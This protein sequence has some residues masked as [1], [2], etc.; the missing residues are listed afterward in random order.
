[1]DSRFPVWNFQS[2]TARPRV[3][4]I[5][6]FARNDDTKSRFAEL[7]YWSL[8]RRVPLRGISILRLRR[9]PSPT[10]YSYHMSY[11]TFISHPARYVPYERG[12]DLSTSLPMMIWSSALH[13]CHTDR[14]VEECLFEAHLSCAFGAPLLQG[15]T[16]MACNTVLSFLCLR[17]YSHTSEAKIPRIRFR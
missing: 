3:T 13:S 10:G 1:M 7:A 14:C 5:S 6:R 15:P 17:I 8:R 16:R 11:R 4:K 12:K 2:L 9:A